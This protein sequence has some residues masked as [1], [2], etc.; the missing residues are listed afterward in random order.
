MEDGKTDELSWLLE[1]DSGKSPRSF[2]SFENVPV[3]KD[4]RL[5][6]RRS[7]ELSRQPGLASDRSF[8]DQFRRAALS[9]MNNIAEGYERGSE[10]ELN[11]FLY[12]AKG[13]CGEVRSML[14]AA[15]DLKML[16]ND[17]K[18]EVHELCLSLSRQL[19][20]FIRHLEA[21]RANISRAPR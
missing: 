2:V 9:V 11:R 4:S 18:A 8:C 14:Y 12:I 15:Q 5:L 16:S 10:A 3:W 7:Y 21:K 1:E 13:S 19:A 17:D 6:V 20:G